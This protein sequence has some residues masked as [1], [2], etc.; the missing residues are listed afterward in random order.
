M[1]LKVSVCLAFLSESAVDN[2]EGAMKNIL[3]LDDNR[4]ICEAVSSRIRRHVPGCRV[5]IAGDGAQGENILSNTAI[6]LVLTDLAMP[7]MNG[8]TLI[9]RAKKHFPNV[10]ICVMTANCSPD[11]VRRLQSL[12]VGR[13]I[14]KP[15]KAE[16]VARMVA[17]VL[18]LPYND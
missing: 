9:E 17:E 6:D 1:N 15:F 14:E 8:Y 12:G 5:L 2:N 3:V 18:A 10:L 16:N 13:W 11:V 7:V 4:D